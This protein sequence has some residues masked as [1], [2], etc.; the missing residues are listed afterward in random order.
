MYLAFLSAGRTPLPD[1]SKNPWIEF[2]RSSRHRYAQ[3]ARIRRRARSTQAREKK[4]K[5][6][7]RA[8]HSGGHNTC[9]R[10][11]AGPYKSLQSKRRCAFDISVVIVH[12]GMNNVVVVHASICFID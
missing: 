10:G 1:W 12:V 5:K 7:K 9:T 2:Y 8:G 3:S 6:E 11:P 4:K